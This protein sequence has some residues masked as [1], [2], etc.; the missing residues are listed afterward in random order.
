MNAADGIAVRSVTVN[1]T[2]YTT[3]ACGIAGDTA[4]KATPDPEIKDLWV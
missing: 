2:L 4:I 1:S 3:P